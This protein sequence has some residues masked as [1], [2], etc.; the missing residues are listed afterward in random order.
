MA[1]NNNNNQIIRKD[2]KNCFV[3]V[4]NDAFNIGK[5]LFNFVSYNTANQAGSKITASIAVYLSFDEFYRICHDITVTKTILKEIYNMSEAAKK[6]GKTFAPQKVLCMGGRSAKS[7]ANANKSRPD[8]M[9]LSRQM[10]IGMGNKLP[11]ILSAESGPGEQNDKGLIVPRYQQ[12]EQRVMVGFTYETI[13][14][15]FLIVKAHLDAYLASKYVYLA[16]H[17]EEQ[18]TQDTRLNRSSQ[19]AQQGSS[20][21]S[22]ADTPPVDNYNAVPNS[23]SHN[24]P[25]AASLPN[26]NELPPVDIDLFNAMSDQLFF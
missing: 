1:N 19:K 13:E 7:L 3:E 17:P 24:N 12:P 6:E 20:S 15:L 11:V 25:P 2:G 16:L 14:E 4:M 22:C 5:V 9:S 26:E 8:G 23:Y 18:P 21:V 10:K